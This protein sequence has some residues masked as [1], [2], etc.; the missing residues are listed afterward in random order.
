M[1][2]I[3]LGDT[4]ATVIT[5][6]GTPK[7]SNSECWVYEKGPLNVCFSG[8]TVSYVRGAHLEQGSQT[9]LSDGDPIKALSEAL[10][11]TPVSSSNVTFYFPT[12]DLLIIATPDGMRIRMMTLGK[13][14][15]A[16]PMP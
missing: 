2:G 1:D 8:D 12:L 3:H 9:L 4:R 13:R 7:R 14:I 5:K 15:D 11:I 16:L 10:P 6:L